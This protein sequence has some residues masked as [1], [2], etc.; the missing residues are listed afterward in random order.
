MQALL[1]CLFQPPIWFVQAYICLAQSTLCT[2]KV[3]TTRARCPTSIYGFRRRFQK[4]FQIRPHAITS[5]TSR[6][7]LGNLRFP[8]VSACN[9]VLSQSF[10]RRAH[11]QIHHI[12][13]RKDRRRSQDSFSHG[14]FQLQRGIFLGEAS[15]WKHRRGDGYLKEYRIPI[16]REG[17]SSHSN[18]AQSNARAPA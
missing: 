10:L 4:P 14:V 12:P 17:S 9:D 11:M 5:T 3:Q 13:Q 7:P 18:P 1:L 8:S 6:A 2:S 15:F 16:L